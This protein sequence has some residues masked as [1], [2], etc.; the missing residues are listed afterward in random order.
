MYPADITIQLATY[1]SNSRALYNEISAD[2]DSKPVLVIHHPHYTDSVRIWSTA[3]GGLK[4]DLPGI[5]F[6]SAGRYFNQ[7]GDQRSTIESVLDKTKNVGTIDFIFR[8]NDNC[9]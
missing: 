4:K 8:I 6:V 1:C 5:K 3:L 2:N 7:D 9:I